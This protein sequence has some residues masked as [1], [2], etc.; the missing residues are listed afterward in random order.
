MPKKPKGGRRNYDWTALTHEY[1]TDP[2]MSL[3][4]LAKKYGIGYDTIA[5]KSKAEGWFATRKKFQSKLVS[6]SISQSCNDQAKALSKE[7]NYLTKLQE[8]YEKM[9]YDSEQYRKHLVETKLIED[10]S[11]LITT[12]EKLFTKYDTRAMR[13]SF[14]MLKMM[15]DLSRSLLDIQRLEAMQKHEIDAARLEL[16]RERFEFEKQKA[17]AFKPTDSNAIR[18]E[19][20]E[21]GWAE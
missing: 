12:E 14:Q 3:R 5:K 15:E 6:K 1:V 9:V 10:N 20:F 11:M 18:I 16:E 21:K 4:K 17:E 13:D 8:H 19:G 2:N 7:S